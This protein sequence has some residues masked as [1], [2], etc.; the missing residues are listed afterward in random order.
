MTLNKLLNLSKIQFSIKL[1]H[2]FCHYYLHWLSFLFFFFFTLGKIVIGNVFL[3]G[4]GECMVS[5]KESSV[6]QYF[7]LSLFGFFFSEI[8]SL[9]KKM[10]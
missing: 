1:Y 6:D 8:M 7:K 5:I 3:M 9:F 2:Y 4:V 10:T